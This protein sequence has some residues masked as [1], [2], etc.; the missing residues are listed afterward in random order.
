MNFKNRQTGD[1]VKA[2]RLSVDGAEK[3]KGGA[4]E[5]DWLVNESEI[6]KPQDFVDKY[7]F[8]D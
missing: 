6:V 3:V 7:E 8:V 4:V 2:H 1:I 5:G